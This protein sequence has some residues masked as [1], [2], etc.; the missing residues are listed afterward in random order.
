MV[1]LTD[2][3]GSSATPAY[4][5]VSLEKEQLTREALQVMLSKAENDRKN[6][7]PGSDSFEKFVAGGGEARLRV[8]KGIA[9]RF[10]DRFVQATASG[11]EQELYKEKFAA[12]NAMRKKFPKGTVIPDRLLYLAG[13]D[14]V[15]GCTMPF[16]EGFKEFKELAPT[17]TPEEATEKLL[18]LHRYV[19]ECHR[20]DIRIGEF[21][22]SNFGFVGD[23]FAFVDGLTFDIPKFPCATKFLQTID[24]E[25]IDPNEELHKDDARAWERLR[26]YSTDTDWFGFSHVVLATLCTHAFKGSLLK[27]IESVEY[28]EPRIRL[29]RGLSIFEPGIVLGKALRLIPEALSEPLYEHLYEV[30][31]GKR[32][33]GVFPEALLKDLRWTRCPSCGGMFAA[34]SCPCG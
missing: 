9:L 28:G 2:R 14:K 29:L 34:R 25:L 23:K 31:S 20:E 3:K 6:P 13:D 18:V 19:V 17:W 11:G 10:E 15:I 27:A 30:F 1:I 26:P 7:D 32:R 12:L 8:H 24:P 5:L 4:E 21:N 16:L 33:R 22:W